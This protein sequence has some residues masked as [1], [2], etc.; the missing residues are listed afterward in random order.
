MLFSQTCPKTSLPTLKTN[1]WKKIQTQKCASKSRK[2][3]VV[4]GWSIILGPPI[5]LV[6]V[7][8]LELFLCNWAFW[9]SSYASLWF[10][11]VAFAVL[12]CNI[13]SD[14]NK[15]WWL[16]YSTTVEPLFNEGPSNWQNLYA[17]TRFRYIEVLFQYFTVTGVKKIVRFIEN[18]VIQ[19]FV[20]SRFHC[21][22]VER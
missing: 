17:R 14:K 5:S 2:C 10:G 19:V 7:K 8:A 16:L 15:L 13:Y 12:S 20:K 4:F 18:F 6:D 21:I 11:A 22:L 3:I 1:A 9:P